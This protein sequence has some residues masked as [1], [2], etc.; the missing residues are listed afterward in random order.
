M[1]GTEFGNVLTRAMV[2]DKFLYFSWL[3]IINDVTQ[4]P[5]VDSFAE[6]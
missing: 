5:I 1:L 2:M 4:C 3:S 6:K